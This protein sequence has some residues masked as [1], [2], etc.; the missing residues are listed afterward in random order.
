M[1]PFIKVILVSCIVILAF[2]AIVHIAHLLLNIGILIIL[3]VG[4]HRLYKDGI[5]KEWLLKMNGK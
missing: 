3:A 2:S 4:I 1:K 5:I